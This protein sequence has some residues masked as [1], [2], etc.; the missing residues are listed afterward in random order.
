[1]ADSASY[2]APAELNRLRTLALG[3][4]GIALI[5][6]AIGVYFNPEQGLRSWLLGFIFWGGIGIGGTGI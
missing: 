5:V 4:G 1:M 2:Q 6:W 3:V